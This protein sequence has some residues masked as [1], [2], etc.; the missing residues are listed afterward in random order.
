MFI[1]VSL[2]TPAKPLDREVEAVLGAYG[3]GPFATGLCQVP[4]AC[5]K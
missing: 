5:W 3:M 4:A 2:A 1:L